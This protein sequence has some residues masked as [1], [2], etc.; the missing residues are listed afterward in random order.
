MT[1]NE[2]PP[3]ACHAPIDPAILADYWLALLPPAEEEAVESHLFECDACGDQL[4][5]I[6]E[7]AE[8]LRA[9]ARSGALRVIVGEEFVRHAGATGRRVRQYDL[10]PGQTVA[11]TISADDDFL[12]ARLAVDL[13]GAARVDLSFRDL[14]GVERGRMNDI[15][16]RA[17]TGHIIFQES[18]TFAK[19]APSSSMVAHLHAVGADG[20]ERLL[21][22]YYF[23]HTR[24][25]P[26]PPGWAW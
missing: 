5:G 16:I 6:I 10:L 17:N 15:P 11:C 18:A 24:T 22:E 26:G 2:D 7:I 20:K 4:R 25:I 12:V 8:A 1:R 21:G 3:A 13:S 9:L 14:Q 23:E 19:A